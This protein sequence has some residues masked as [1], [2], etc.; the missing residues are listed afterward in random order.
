MS[1]SMSSKELAKLL[2][3]SPSAVSLALNHKKGVS[4]ATRQKIL[5]AAEEHGV[6]FERAAAAGTGFLNLV[7]FKSHGMVFGDTPFFS[8]LLEGVGESAAAH[9]F[10]LQVSYFYKNQDFAEQL[11]PLRAP[12]CNGVILLATEATQQDI[13]A[14]FS[15]DRPLVIL[16]SAC[17]NEI[18]DTVSINNEAGAF[19]ATTHLIDCGH[20]SLAHIASSVAIANFA[21]RQMGFARAVE[22]SVHSEHISSCV[23]PVGP[24]QET[25]YRDMSQFLDTHKTLPTA[26]FA[27]NDLIALACIRAMR[28]HHIRVPDNVSVVGFDNIS[29]DYLTSHRLTTIDVPK[30]F[31]GKC[32]VDRLIAR[33]EDP[34]QTHSLSIL[35]NTRLITRNTVRRI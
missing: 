6:R 10:R 11:K 9:G 23:I 16:D 27:D 31:M 18:F 29:L 25:A 33:I 34:S 30:R 19:H 24:T 35:V 22:R 32:A 2:G 8:E 21:E 15:L 28:D 14:F 20:R 5:Q 4:E 7:I 12:G 1:I 26:M 13:S 3:V 17:A